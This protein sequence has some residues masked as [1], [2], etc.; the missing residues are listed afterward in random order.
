MVESD[1]QIEDAAMMQDYIF[2]PV[3]Q[4]DFK[5]TADL[6]EKQASYSLNGF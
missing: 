4:Y 3:I 5:T 2:L 6:G 1:S